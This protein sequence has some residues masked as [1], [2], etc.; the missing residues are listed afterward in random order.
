ME[1]RTS[2]MDLV[3][4]LLEVSGILNHGVYVEMRSRMHG[5]PSKAG[6]STG[7]NVKGLF[8][9]ASIA[10][11]VYLAWKWEPNNKYVQLIIAEGFEGYLWDERFFMSS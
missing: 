8:G 10:E 3:L 4:S 6:S 11:S 7:V 9:A 5:M 2:S 1:E